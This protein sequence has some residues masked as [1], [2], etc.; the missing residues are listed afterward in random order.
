MRF[1]RTTQRRCALVVVAM[2]ALLATAGEKVSAQAAP[3][4][5]GCERLGTSLEQHACFHAEFGP[6]VSVAGDL[7]GTPANV[8]AVHTHYNVQLATGAGEVTYR[9]AR[10][11]SWSIFT[12]SPLEVVVLDAENV[13]VPA[14]L[15]VDSAHCAQLR[16]AQVY[17]LEA[18]VRYRIVLG[19]A[20]ETSVGLVL[21]RLGDFESSHYRDADTDGFGSREDAFV[22]ACV[23]PAGHTSEAGD[24][25]DTN[26]LIHPLA[27][28]VADGQDNDCDGLVDE[29]VGGEV[30]RLYY[31]DQDGDGFGDQE[32]AFEAVSPPSG[33]MATGGDC[34]D[35]R[36]DIHPGGTEVCDNLDNDCDGESDEGFQAEPAGDATRFL[37]YDGDGYGSPGWTVVG[38]GA[39]A[40]GPATDDDC[41][42]VNPA[43]HPGAEEVCDGADNNCDEQVDVALGGADVCRQC[44]PIQLQ[45]SWN[46]RE[47]G[48]HGHA[49]LAAPVQ[50]RIP[51]TI[52]IAQGCAVGKL[53]RLSM[54]SGARTT[55]CHYLGVGA[56]YRLLRCSAGA[57]AGNELTVQEL[58]LHASGSRFCGPTQVVLTLAPVGCETAELAR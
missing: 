44:E 25:D 34:N 53:A 23:P 21:E 4:Y 18:N 27:L 16:R 22:T 58:W 46:R 19:P 26:D 47:G 32:S 1:E 38:C 29:G 43:L 48:R 17:A 51:R 24:C 33:Y 3:P 30:T 49:L 45:A 42:D 8:N 20:E 37:D 14:Q 40:V 55:H 39:A 41:D 52:A 50:V 36:T 9:P 31:L 5:A 7:P 10:A 57:G 56:E 28:E 6:F 35:V 11:G 15:S 13:E 12:S 54:R 2:V